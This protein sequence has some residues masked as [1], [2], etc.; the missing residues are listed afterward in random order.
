MTNTNKTKEGES[1]SPSRV[2]LEMKEDIKF[3]EELGN[4]VFHY[5]RPSGDGGTYILDEKIPESIAK[6]GEEIILEYA[7]Q[8]VDKYKK[9]WKRC[10]DKEKNIRKNHIP[11]TTKYGKVQ[12]EGRIVEATS[13]YIGVELD[14]PLKGKSGI[15][16]GYA[17]AIAGHHVFTENHEI[18]QC[19]YDSAKRALC[20]AH[21]KAINK[22]KKDLAERLNQKL[23]DS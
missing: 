9:K 16:F 14:K 10:E 11:I 13:K 15:N 7:S 4:I 3:E 5:S 21:D 22:P 20:W 23:S 18:S 1:A 6:Q 12:L 19:G 17:S 8:I 2:E